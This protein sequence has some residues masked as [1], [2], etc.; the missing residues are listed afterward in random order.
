MSKIAF[1]FP[2]QGSQHL[3]MA[4]DL[5]TEFPIVKETF[6][7]ASEALSFDLW[8]LC[9]EGPEQKLNSTE[10]TQP[11]LLTASVA[12]WRALNQKITPNVAMMAGHSLGEYSALVCAGAIDF[13]DG[14]RLV[15]TRGKLMTEAVPAGQGTMAAI[16][17]LEDDSVAKVCAETSGSVQ[18]ANYNSP[19]QVVIAGETSAVEAAMANCKEAGAKRALGLPVS[20]PFH[21][22]LMKPAAEKFAEALDAIQVEV[23]SVPVVQNVTNLPQNDA[24]EIKSLL[25][26]QL[27]SPVNWTGAVQYMSAQGVEKLVECGPGKVL[28]GLTKRIDKS[29]SAQHLNDVASL[30]KIIEFLG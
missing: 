8:A 28:T 3:S 15:N 18:P 6:E 11:A 24:A 20:G 25:T 16:I 7:Q 30:E 27:Y 14:V 13:A 17:G 4:A 1:V 22:E 29:V 19:G 21:S 2:G 9:Q 26:Q 5:A 10:N 12:F 23:P